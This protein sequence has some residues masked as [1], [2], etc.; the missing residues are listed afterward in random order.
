MSQIAT[1]IV[2]STQLIEAGLN[3]ESADMAWWIMK[4]QKP[5]LVADTKR[6]LDKGLL[7]AKSIAPLVEIVPAWSLARLIE[8]YG[9]DA[10]EEVISEWVRKIRSILRSGEVAESDEI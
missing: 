1:S 4:G 5:A 6:N 10:P 2:Q 9:V 8:L 3:P 7:R